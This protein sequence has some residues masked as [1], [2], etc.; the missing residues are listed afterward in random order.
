MINEFEGTHGCTTNTLTLWAYF[1]HGITTCKVANRASIS[2]YV[3]M[4]VKPSIVL[5]STDQNLLGIADSPRQIANV[6]V[7][8]DNLRCKFYSEPVN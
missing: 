3:C 7:G 5:Y 8:L 6:T 1:C 4:K 2:K